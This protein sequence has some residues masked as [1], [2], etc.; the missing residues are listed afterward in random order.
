M[1]ALVVVYSSRANVIPTPE[2]GFIVMYDPPPISGCQDQVRQA[3]SPSLEN[4]LRI[5]TVSNQRGVLIVE[6]RKNPHIAS[7]QDLIADPPSCAALALYIGGP[8]GYIKDGPPGAV[9][10]GQILLKVLIANREVMKATVFRFSRPENP[11][12]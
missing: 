8:T 1:L 9:P 12:A 11:E 6:E 2:N 10:G 3:H 7:Y 4:V 5:R